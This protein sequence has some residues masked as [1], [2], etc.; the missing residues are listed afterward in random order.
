MRI[1]IIVFTIPLIGFAMV[2]VPLMFS[3]GN[4]QWKYLPERKLER[5][6]TSYFASHT[7]SPT[8][9]IAVWVGCTVIPTSCNTIPYWLPSP[10]WVLLFLQLFEHNAAQSHGTDITTEFVQYRAENV[11]H[12]I[13]P[14]DK[15]GTFHGM[16][17]IAAITS[18]ICWCGRVQIHFHKEKSS[19]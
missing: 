17:M 1:A 2:V 14:L 4:Y 18:E 19:I 8:S 12:N 16:G 9:S 11:D 10:S 3:M 13:C 7:S 15:H 6:V 5:K